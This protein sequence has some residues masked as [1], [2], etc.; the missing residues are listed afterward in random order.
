MEQEKIR[1]LP[2]G[3]DSVEVFNSNSP[4]LVLESGI[5]LSTFPPNGRAHSEAH[6]DYELQDR[7]DVFLHHVT[8]VKLAKSKSTLHLGLLIGNSTK[9]SVTVSVLSSCSNT[10]TP[11]APFIS[12]DSAIDN[13]D[14]KSFAGPGDKTMLDLLNTDM[15]T[16]AGVLQ[17]LTLAPDEIAVLWTAPLQVPHFHSRNGLTAYLRIHSTGGVRLAVVSAFSQSIRDNAK[18]Q[19]V[20]DTIS[21]P[22]FRT[23]LD[24]LQNGTLVEPRDKRPSLPGGGGDLI[25][26]RVA[27]VSRGATWTGNAVTEIMR[28]GET[29]SYVINTLPGGTFGTGQNQSAPMLVRY[30]DTALQSHGNYGLLYELSFPVHNETFQPIVVAL[31]FQSPIKDD[32][33][34]TLRFAREPSNSIVFRGSVEIE[35]TDA[36]RTS[37]KKRIHLVQTRGQR[38]SPLVKIELAPEE[39]LSILFRLR[40]PPDSTP[41][42]VVTLTSQSQL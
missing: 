11:D 14:S 21:S 8:D 39:T 9:E 22:D 34:N 3:L 13:A 6:L 5:L 4:E 33:K 23:W 32:R 10:T 24:I 29:I 28:A 7:F 19:R 17:T 25:Y 1:A 20:K 27:G 2:G 15:N 36:H 12:L 35:W 41:P 37:H 16:D 38:S 30:T 40:Y 26:G 42:H 18:T 31:T